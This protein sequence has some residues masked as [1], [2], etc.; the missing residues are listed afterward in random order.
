M[1]SVKDKVLEVMKDVNGP[2]KTAE[3]VEATNEAKSAVTKAIKEL[4]DDGAVFSP[5]RCYYQAK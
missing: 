2:M 3:I 5:K 4:K 1:S